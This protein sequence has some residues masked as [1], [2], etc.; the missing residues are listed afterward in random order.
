VCTSSNGAAS[1]STGVIAFNEWCD[2]NDPLDIRRI[3]GKLHQ[4][5]EDILEGSIE[6]PDESDVA[7]KLRNIYGPKLFKC[8]YCSPVFHEQWFETA[9]RRL[10]HEDKH[11]RP[12]K[13]DREG[14]IYFEVGFV[15]KTGLQRHLRQS[16][17]SRG[18]R[19]PRNLDVGYPSIWGCSY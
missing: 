11:S 5:L 4:I 17:D 6:V 7:E 1:N 10:L 12:Y 3:S 15:T 16:H 8:R 13:C 18:W 19:Q 2:K 9:T 14:C